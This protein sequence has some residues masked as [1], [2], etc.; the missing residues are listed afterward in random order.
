MRKPKLSDEQVKLIRK[1][2]GKAPGKPG[3][4]PKGVVT[5][6]AFADQ[7]RCSVDTI[8]NAVLGRG[9]YAACV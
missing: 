2:Y 8:R 6:R 4:R 9:A 1:K 7:Y 3:R 5:M